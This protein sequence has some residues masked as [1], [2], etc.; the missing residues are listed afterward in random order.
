M[1]KQP[2]RSSRS[3]AEAN[4]GP[5]P[6]SMTLK[7]L[8]YTRHLRWKISMIGIQLKDGPHLTWTW[9]AWKLCKQRSQ[10]PITLADMLPQRT[11]YSKDESD[12]SSGK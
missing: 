2:I 1:L 10:M 3:D 6:L 4:Q 5:P 8:S 11:N 12:L 7:E 9:K